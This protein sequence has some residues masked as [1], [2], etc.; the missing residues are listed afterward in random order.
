M[1]GTRSRATRLRCSWPSRPSIPCI[2]DA[3]CE[4]ARLWTPEDGRPDRVGQYHAV[5]GL[6]IDASKVGD[7]HVFRRWGYHPPII[8]DGEIK[9]ALERTGIVG[10]RFDEV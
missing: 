4:E 3:A 8:M 9:E 1:S 5:S 6:R 2:D 10:G 7:A